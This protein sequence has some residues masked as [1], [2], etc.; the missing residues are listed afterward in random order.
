LRS[1]PRCVSIASIAQVV[2]TLGAAERPV[3]PDKVRLER[4]MRE[5]AIDDERRGHPERPEQSRRPAPWA[6]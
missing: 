6:R 1:R 4:Q 2:A 3:M 5:L